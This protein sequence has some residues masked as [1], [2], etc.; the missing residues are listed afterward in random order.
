MK[1]AASEPELGS[2]VTNTVKQLIANVLHGRS[3]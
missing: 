1:M 2:V 3:R